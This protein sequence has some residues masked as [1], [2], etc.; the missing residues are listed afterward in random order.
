MRDP[1]FASAVARIAGVTALALTVAACGGGG[2][3]SAAPPSPP[4]AAPASGL[5]AW[6]I[7]AEGSTASADAAKKGLSLV[8]PTQRDVEVQVEPASAVITDV[9]PIAAGRVD[10]TAA[11]VDAL[12]TEGL[13][14]IIG[15]DVRYLPLRAN[16]E[17]PAQRVQRARST[18]ACAFVLDAIDHGSLGRSRF[19]VSTAGAD[20]RCDTADDGNA[21]VRLDPALG[22]VL[23]PWV[24]PAPLAVMRDPRTLAPRGWLT[25]T[26]SRPLEGAAVAL[27][28]SGDPWTRAVMATLRSVLV[29]SAAGLAAVDFDADGKATERTLPALGGAGWQPIGFD[30]RHYF[31]YRND[32]TPS[33]PSWAVWR[34]DRVTLSSVTMAAGTGRIVLS[35]MGEEVLYLSVAGVDRFELR[36]LPKAVP[37][38][39]Q[40]IESGPSSA[41]ETSYFQVIASA[42]RVHLLWRVRGSG[43]AALQTSVELVDESGQVL[44][45]GVDGSSLGAAPAARIDLERSENRSRFM[46]IEG[47]GARLYGDATLVSY[48]ATT[49]TATRLGALP[50]RA[51]FGDDLVFVGVVPSSP[52]LDAGFASRSVAGVIQSAGTRV[53]TVEPGRAASLVIATQT[54]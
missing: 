42:H 50:G 20:G 11:R 19:V 44:Y 14:Y 23:A 51:V 31:V 2:E 22:P 47:F 13:L 40:L 53:F 32:G 43:N 30:G 36:R 37:G 6:L 26:E 25:P 15:G 1:D 18:S 5:Y 54:R 45:R 33:A 28:P 7:K 12:E 52:V 27:R 24:G 46:F 34:I 41:S 21:E 39:S 8:H 10:A 16:G 4:V 38:V 49:R 3:G 17:A 35:A 48:D 9:K 29:E